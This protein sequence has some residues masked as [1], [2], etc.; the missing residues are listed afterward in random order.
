MAFNPTQAV[1]HNEG[2]DLHYWYQGQGPLVFFIPGGNGHGRQYNPIITALSDRFTCATFDRRG[3]SASKVAVNKRLNPGQQA[4]DIFTIVKDM[5][6]DKGIFFGSS[7]GGKLGYV[8]AIDY[9][10]LIEHLIVHE[11]PI[12]DLLPNHSEFFEWFLNTLEVRDTQGWE[13]ARPI[14]LEKFV[15]FDRTPEELAVRPRAQPERENDV[16]FYANE[17]E[18]ATMYS[19]NLH[20]IKENGTSVGIMRGERSGDAFYAVSTYGQAQI[21]GCPRLDVPGHHLGFESEVDAFVPHFYKMLD[22]LEARKT[23][24]K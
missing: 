21:L 7:L 4:R 12:I 5:G 3:M 8:L 19:P 11:A 22:I 20:A 9:P 23:D 6:F 24:G 17:I 15:G 18:I 10:E 13:A 2:C 16:N 1:V 14:F